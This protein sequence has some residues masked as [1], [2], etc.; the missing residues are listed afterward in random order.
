MFRQ[1]APPLFLVCSRQANI[2]RNLFVSQ[3]LDDSPGD[4]IPSLISPNQIK[5][6]PGDLLIGQHQIDRISPPLNGP[7]A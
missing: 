1:D 2:G 3:G 7:P 5:E 4:L 6:D